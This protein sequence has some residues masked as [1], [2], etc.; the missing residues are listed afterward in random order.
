MRRRVSSGLNN[1]SNAAPMKNAAIGLWKKIATC[2][3]DMINE[4]RIAVSN[5]G[6]MTNPSTIGAGS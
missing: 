5:N 4:R 3:L 6:P 2:P 1:M